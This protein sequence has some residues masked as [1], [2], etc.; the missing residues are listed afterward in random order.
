MGGSAITGRADRLSAVWAARVGGWLR[1]FAITSIGWRADIIRPGVDARERSS[2]RGFGFGVRA[3]GAHTV[4]PR[5]WS[6]GPWPRLDHAD[7][8]RLVGA[9]GCAPLRLDLR[10]RGGLIAIRPHGRAP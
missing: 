4:R 3:K 5:G 8:I 7:A 6:T 2:R 1:A 9:H 10:S